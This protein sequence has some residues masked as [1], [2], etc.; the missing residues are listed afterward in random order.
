MEDGHRLKWQNQQGGQETES[1]LL[2]VHDYLVRL[3]HD[4]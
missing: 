4:K 2:R 1:N 3:I